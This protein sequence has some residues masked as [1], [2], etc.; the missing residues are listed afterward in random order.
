MIR[1]HEVGDRCSMGFSTNEIIG[2]SGPRAWKLINSTWAR[3]LAP[4]Y[5]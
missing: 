2:R 3:R 4:G 5:G 1:A